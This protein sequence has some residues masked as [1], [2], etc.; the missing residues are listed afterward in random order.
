MF[1][2]APVAQ[3]KRLNNS[4]LPRG[5]VVVYASTVFYSFGGHV[6]RLAST[7]TLAILLSGCSF[8]G[9][10]KDEIA[11]AIGAPPNYISDVSCRSA[12]NAPGHVCS[13]V[14]TTPTTGYGIFERGSSTNLT[15]RFVKSDTG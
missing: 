13:F 14:M 8:G 15:R 1:S 7:V 10:S 9:P 4:H 12:D 6:N 11:S 5:R 3:L 2:C